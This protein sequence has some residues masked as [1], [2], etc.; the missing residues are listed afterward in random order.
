MSSGED[1]LASNIQLIG[2]TTEIVELP[3]HAPVYLPFG[4]IATRPS[5]WLQIT[6]DVEGV[7]GYGA[8]EGTSLPMQIPM[9]DD[10]SGNLQ[11][12]ID[13]LVGNLCGEET[14]VQ[15]ARMAIAATDL[16]GNFATARMT[17]EAAILDMVS[18]ASNTT[19]YELL[20]GDRSDQPLA[21]PYGKSIAEAECPKIIQ[22]GLKAA[23]RG[24]QRLKFKLSPANYEAVIEGITNL[25]DKIPDADFMV[26]ANGTFDPENQEHRTILHEV[27]GLKLMMIEEPVSRGGR[28][29]GLA[30]H[31]ALQQL[32]ALETPIALDDSLSTRED[33]QVALDEGL[34][35]ILNLKPGRVGSFLD[36]LD[37]AALAKRRGKQIMVGGMFE[38]TPGRMMTLTLAAICLR[39]GFTIPG[40]VSLPQER[41]AGDITTDDQ[42]ELDSEH[43]VVFRPKLGWGYGL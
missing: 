19:V 15:A 24:A 4:T 40:D 31:R 12:N 28:L 26:D 32:L 9:Y 42:L 21:I 2:H 27:D 29:S 22:A 16:G 6:G 20:T 25:K 17:V 41:L 11:S 5:A 33:A 23:E 36:C 8:A 34:G 30:A 39:E 3:F 10:Y 14:T 7:Q 38:A 37:M 1:F 13:T 35:A 43:N 18:R